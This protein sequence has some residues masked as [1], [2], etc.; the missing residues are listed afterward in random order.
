MS[1]QSSINLI[2]NEENS[3]KGTAKYALLIFNT[4]LEDAACIG[5]TEKEKIKQY[6]TVGTDSMLLTSS[7]KTKVGTSP[8]TEHDEVLIDSPFVSGNNIFN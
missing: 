6:D 7:P 1:Q 5:E 8:V 2:E 3:Q 4:L